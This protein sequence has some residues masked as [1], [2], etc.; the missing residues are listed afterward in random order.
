MMRRISASSCKRRGIQEQVISSSFQCRLR[1]MSSMVAEV[2]NEFKA[3]KA[4]H[5]GSN[6]DAAT[7]Q[8]LS[9]DN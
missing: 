7:H 2:D 5:H 3:F 8:E 9:F 4:C 6:S 1:I